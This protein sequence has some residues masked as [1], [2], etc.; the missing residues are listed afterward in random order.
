MPV[1]GAS[2]KTNGA[3]NGTAGATNGAAGATNGTG[4][5]STEVVPVK[6]E[7]LYPKAGD[8]EWERTGW[9]PRFGN[10][11]DALGVNN[12]DSVVDHQTFVESN[13]DEKFFGGTCL[14]SP[15]FR[16]EAHGL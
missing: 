12:E 11:N 1:P 16:D 6:K 5:V 7:P 8:G 9:E 3:T 13:L 15:H 2:S 14:E 4:G 10:M